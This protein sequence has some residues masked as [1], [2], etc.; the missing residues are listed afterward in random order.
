MIVLNP[1]LY[2]FNE[3]SF[4]QISNSF[5]G[6]KFPILSC[7]E[8]RHLIKSNCRLPLEGGVKKSKNVRDVKNGR[9]L[10]TVLEENYI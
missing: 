8:V 3:S 4:L 5:S 7:V 6:S 1:V 9:P 10:S 2:H